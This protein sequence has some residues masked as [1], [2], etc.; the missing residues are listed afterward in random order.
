MD[1][2]KIK[3]PENNENIVQDIDKD[4]VEDGHD[5]DPVEPEQL[6][7]VEEDRQVGNVSIKVD[8]KYLTHGAPASILFLI[9]LGIGAGQGKIQSIAQFRYPDSLASTK[10]YSPTHNPDSLRFERPQ[11]L[12]K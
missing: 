6:Q 7:E 4:H 12:R 9:L 5:H 11:Y 1:E 8:A 10:L 3:M 2:V